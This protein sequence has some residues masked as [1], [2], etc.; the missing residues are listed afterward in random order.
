MAGNCYPCRF[1]FGVNVSPAVANRVD[2]IGG[3]GYFEDSFDDRAFGTDSDLRHVRLFT[4]QE[5]QGVEEHCF[6]GTGFTG[7]CRESRSEFDRCIL[8]DTEVLDPNLIDHGRPRS[9]KPLTGKSNFLTRRPEN[10][11]SLSLARYTG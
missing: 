8:D 5:P 3:F 7:D 4:K 1:T 10:G 2:D 6:T 9:R 11:V